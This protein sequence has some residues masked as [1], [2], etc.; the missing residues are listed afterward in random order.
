MRPTFSLLD[1]CSQ[2]SSGRG[3]YARAY[4]RRGA[5]ETFAQIAAGHD[6]PILWIS[7]ECEQSGAIL[8]DTKCDRRLPN[9]SRTV[10]PLPTHHSASLLHQFWRIVHQHLCQQIN[11][12]VPAS[13]QNAHRS[14]VRSMPAKAVIP[15]SSADC[16][17]NS[18]APLH[19]R[20]P[21]GRKLSISRFSA[22]CP[23]AIY[24]SRDARSLALNQS[25]R[26]VT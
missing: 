2:R 25:A 4:Q 1:M 5:A 13:D 15:I 17:S 16:P 26:T 22:D 6:Q 9:A 21:T 10:S 18:T 12:D 7:T 19:Q 24:P 3:R 14:D 20:P 11:A 8:F 23:I